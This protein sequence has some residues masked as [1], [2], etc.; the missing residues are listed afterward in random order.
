MKGFILIF[1]T[2]PTN[3]NVNISFKIIKIKE[4]F[5]EWRGSFDIFLFDQRKCYVEAMVRAER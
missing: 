3:K 4:L 5:I 1:V 2:F